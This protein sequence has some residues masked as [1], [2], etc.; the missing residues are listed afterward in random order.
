M[1]KDDFNLFNFLGIDFVYT[2][3][4]IIVSFLGQ[5]FFS[6]LLTRDSSIHSF[7]P[8]LFFLKDNWEF[9]FLVCPNLKFKRC[10]NLQTSCAAGA[11]WCWVLAVSAKPFFFKLLYACWDSIVCFRK[12]PMGLDDKRNVKP[13]VHKT[14]NFVQINWLSFW[15]IFVYLFILYLI[16]TF[17]LCTTKLNTHPFSPWF[18]FCLQF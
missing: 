14:Q 15:F 13:Y 17:W 6:S 9:L 8:L 12:F 5:K 3:I 7:I 2:F 18:S 10:N 4:F 16:L 1:I 11:S